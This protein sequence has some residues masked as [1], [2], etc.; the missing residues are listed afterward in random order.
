MEQA[1]IP[2]PSL[3]VHAPPALSNPSWGKRLLMPLDYEEDFGRC[4][5]RTHLSLSLPGYL[6]EFPLFPPGMCQLVGC[7]STG[8]GARQAQHKT[9]PVAS[10]CVSAMAWAVSRENISFSNFQDRGDGSWLI[11]GRV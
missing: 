3:H 9:V 5:V 8:E 4:D 2:Q 10:A 1:S 6:P 7:S 11:T